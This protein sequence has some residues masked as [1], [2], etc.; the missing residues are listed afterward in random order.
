MHRSDSFCIFVCI[1]VYTNG[2]GVCVCA[3]KWECLCRV[4]SHDKIYLHTMYLMANPLKLMKLF[5]ILY[6]F[7]QTHWNPFGRTLD[8]IIQHINS[9]VR[10]S[11]R[12]QKWLQFQVSLELESENFKEIQTGKYF[13][14]N[15][16]MCW[17]FEFADPLWVFEGTSENG[18]PNVEIF[19]A[20][21]HSKR[22]V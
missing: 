1:C 5:N 19:V 9:H 16:W 17:P 13:I 21:L 4:F 15:I 11:F 18:S 8:Q 12:K 20:L 22:W 14:L 2:K 6:H 3:S 10:A 7:A